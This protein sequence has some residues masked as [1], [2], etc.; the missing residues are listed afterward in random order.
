AIGRGRAGRRA[1]EL[2]ALL[3][4]RV[5]AARRGGRAGGGHAVRVGRRRAATSTGGLGADRLGGGR[6]G[7]GLLRRSVLGRPQAGEGHRA[8]VRGGRLVVDGGRPVP[9]GRVAARPRG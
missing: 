1:G 9:L 3:E 7:S 8:R 6:R 2:V 4:P 5:P